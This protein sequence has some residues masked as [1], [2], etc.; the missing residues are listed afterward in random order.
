MLVWSS[1]ATLIPLLMDIT[2]IDG[3]VV[4]MKRLGGGSSSS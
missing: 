1:Y 4:E 2:S 3:S